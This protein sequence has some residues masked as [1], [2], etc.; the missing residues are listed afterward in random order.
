ME[1]KIENENFEIGLEDGLR[2]HFNGNFDVLLQDGDVD[3]R[4]RDLSMYDY[5][6]LYPIRKEIGRKL[7]E[8][9]ISCIFHFL[10]KEV[11]FDLKMKLN[12]LLEHKFDLYQS[13]H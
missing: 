7:L 2:S 6:Q 8:F 11:D 3:I 1:F 13:L 5:L 4:A 12:N 10:A 9:Q